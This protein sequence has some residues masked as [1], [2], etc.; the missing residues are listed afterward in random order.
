MKKID[1]ESN[2]INILERE[3]EAC[4]KEDSNSARE[5]YRLIK[6]VCLI[7]EFVNGIMINHIE[8]NIKNTCFKDEA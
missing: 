1:I 8:I 6:E 5:R 4:Y 2:C 3:C 7:N